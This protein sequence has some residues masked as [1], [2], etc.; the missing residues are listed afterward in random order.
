MLSGHSPTG[1]LGQPGCSAL[2]FLPSLGSREALSV[3]PCLTP[4]T[5]ACFHS[6]R[7]VVWKVG[8]R[9]HV[10]EMS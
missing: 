6:L 9:G 5:S 4:P 1:A 7:R 2:W 10:A 8:S 3:C